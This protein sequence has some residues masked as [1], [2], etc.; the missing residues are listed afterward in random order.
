MLN[1][2]C[3]MRYVCFVTVATHTHE[4]VAYRKHMIANMNLSTYFMAKSVCV[5]VSVSVCVRACVNVLQISPFT[6]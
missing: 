1:A 4:H 2:A 5:C 6:A 3:C